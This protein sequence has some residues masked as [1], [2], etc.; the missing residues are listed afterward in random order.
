MAFANKT[1]RVKPRARTCQ[2]FLD[3]WM[4][5]VRAH[6]LPI[7]ID[8]S[9]RDNAITMTDMRIPS[10]LRTGVLYTTQDVHDGADHVE[11]DFG[12]RVDA[13]LAKGLK[14]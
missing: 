7:E 12:K 3:E 1:P 4:P 14:G 6:G 13:F 2:D 9:F 11:G 5:K 10:A 8:F